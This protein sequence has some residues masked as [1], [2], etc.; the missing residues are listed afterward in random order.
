M[1]ASAVMERHWRPADQMHAAS[2]SSRAVTRLRDAVA[3]T[4]RESLPHLA[5][6]D[7]SEDP[8]SE[9]EAERILAAHRAR[10]EAKEREAEAVRAAQE[11][12]KDVVM[13][14]HWGP[15]AREFAISKA[16]E[17]LE[18]T[19]QAAIDALKAADA[20]ELQQARS[21]VC[22]QVLTDADFLFVLHEFREAYYLPSVPTESSLRDFASCAST[23][24]SWHEAIRH[25]TRR[26]CHL[27]HGHMRLQGPPPLVGFNRPS[28]LE[29]TPTDELLI[30]DNHK[31]SIVPIS[32]DG[33]AATGTATDGFAA[34]AVAALATTAAAIS[35]SS[36]PL[37]SSLSTALA[38]PR[39]RFA[40]AAAA[41]TTVQPPPRPHH[42]TT[43]RTIGSNNGSGG[44]GIGELY[45]P[46]G[47]ALSADNLE[48][49]PTPRSNASHSLPDIALSMC[50]G[51]R[52]RPLQPSR[53]V[54][55]AIRRR[56]AGLHEQRRRVGAV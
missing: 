50:A 36:R 4:R 38:S 3:T 1:S 40:A 22:R 52:R 9:E 29:V 47:L 44:S 35:S 43:F 14:P 54:L 17:R 34:T 18:Q 15:A 2:P 51:V 23:C 6:E 27:Y 10:R 33:I 55:A 31:V 24:K 26:R 37:P 39:S 11:E 46:H 13:Q 56:S 19:R 21:E 48:V 42:H 45:H 20:L 49:H 41:A 16:R 8:D 32:A 53:A 7:D 12:V 25:V 30:S 28:F 5:S